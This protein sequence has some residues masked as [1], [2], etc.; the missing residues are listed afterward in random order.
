MK[1][2]TEVMPPI[3]FSETVVTVT[4]KFTYNGYIL[5]KVKIIFPQNLLHY[6]HTFPPFYEMPYAGL[7]KNLS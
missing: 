5:Y 2:S 4:M 7:V 6:Q 1:A 3:F